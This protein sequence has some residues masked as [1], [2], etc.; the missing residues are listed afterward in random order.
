MNSMGFIVFI[1][2]RTRR[3]LQEG[4]VQRRLVTGGLRD[5]SGSSLQE[6][7]E[8]DQSTSPIRVVRTAKP[9]EST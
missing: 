6:K 2:F 3:L 5:L 7:H 4:G 1:V 9:T 8:S